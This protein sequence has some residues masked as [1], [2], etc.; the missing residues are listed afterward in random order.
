MPTF[1]LGGKER[2]LCRAV[3][4]GDQAKLG[5]SDRIRA[6]VLRHIILGLPLVDEKDSTPAKPIVSGES[7]FD[8]LA[9]GQCC[10]KTGAGI[11]IRGGVIIGRLKIDSALGDCG[12]P[13]CPLTFEGTRFVGGF[14][15]AHSHFS[16]LSFKDCTFLDRGWNVDRA[17]RRPLPTL[18]LSG[19]RLDGNLQMGGVHPEPEEKSLFWIRA[20]GVRVGGGIE[21]SHCNLRSPAPR[22]GPG[23]WQVTEDALD[24][25]LAEIGGD[26]VLRKGS[27]ISGRLKMRGAQIHGDLWIEGA[28]IRSRRAEESMFL[29][30]VQVAGY[31]VMRRDGKEPFKCDRTVDLTG[32]EVGRS[33]ILGAEIGGAIKAPDLTVRDDFFLH[34]KVRGKIDLGHMTIGGSLDLSHLRVRGLKT[35]FFDTEPKVALLLKDGGIGRELSLARIKLNGG[36]PFRLDGTADLT[37]LTCDTLDDDIGRSWGAQAVI[38]M[39]HF[40]YRRAS[41]LSED[42]EKEFKKTSYEVVA[43]WVQSWIAEIQWPARAISKR[44]RNSRFLM[45]WQLRRNWIYR[46]FESDQTRMAAADSFVSITRHRIREHEYRPQPFEQAIR[47]A[48]AE[49]R[50]DIATRFEMLKQRIEWRFVNRGVRWPLGFVAIISA[51]LWLYGHAPADWSRPVTLAALLLTL[52]LMLCGTWIR[53]WLRDRVVPSVQNSGGAAALALVAEIALV[54][55]WFNHSGRVASIFGFLVVSMSL[56]IL[57]IQG[58][59]IAVWLSKPHPDFPAPRESDEETTSANMSSK[60]LTW[61]TYWMPAVALLVWTDL[62]DRPFHYLVAFVIFIA[63]RMMG[64]FAHLIMRFGFGYLRRPIRAVA[65]LIAAFLIGWMAIVVANSRD[66]FVIAAEPTAESAAMID[67]WNTQVGADGVEPTAEAGA[68]LTEPSGP[69]TTG[70]HHEELLLMGSPEASGG[71]LIRDLPCSHEISEPLYAL[72]V[73]IPIVD[74]G[75]E[76]RCEIRRFHPPGREPASPDELPLARLRASVP[77]LTINNHRFWW[78]MKAI[79]AIFGWII[80]SLSILTFAQVNKIHAEPPTEHK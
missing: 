66:M 32:V 27:R 72:D 13:I 60:V 41:S 69:E 36:P 37:G 6:G 40:T 53:G 26:L 16:H 2:E 42:K 71:R 19:A 29:Q 64:I 68:H 78:W 24:L 18:D 52:A 8:E 47:V 31:L 46:Q 20:P 3:Q 11:S 30:G 10:P 22:I 35:P 45:Q 5:E 33:L 51:S 49:G 70:H 14:S 67:P 62:H 73:L 75:E 55:L 38:R 12:V 28:N 63:I 7:P 77:D 80:V 9:R 1:D 44:W 59:R 57:V 34:G 23:T 56:A 43:G 48:R 58:S 15:G 74:L 39:N 76:S 61:L 65:T 25:T 21:L 50:E 4:H 17:T 54:V 79:Y